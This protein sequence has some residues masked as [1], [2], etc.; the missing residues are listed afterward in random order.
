MLAKPLAQLCKKTKGADVNIP[1]AGVNTRE[2]MGTRKRV[3]YFNHAPFGGDFPCAAPITSFS[4]EEEKKS[5]AA[6]LMRYLFRGGGEKKE[7][8]MERP[9]LCAALTCGTLIP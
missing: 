7:T 2:P 3:I 5:R 4:P 6:K 1:G 9:G 8:R